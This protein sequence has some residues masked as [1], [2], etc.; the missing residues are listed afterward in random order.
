MTCAPV[1]MPNAVLSELVPVILIAGSS[2]PATGAAELVLSS[3]GEDG[4][5]D[6]GEEAADESEVTACA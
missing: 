3:E 5:F 6:D 1:G 2:L 4:E